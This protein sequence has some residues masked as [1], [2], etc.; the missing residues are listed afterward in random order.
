VSV[1]DRRNAFLRRRA[2]ALLNDANLAAMRQGLLPAGWVYGLNDQRQAEFDEQRRMLI[3]GHKYLFR[4]PVT[5]PDGVAVAIWYEGTSEYRP[6]LLVPYRQLPGSPPDRFTAAV[7]FCIRVINRIMRGIYPAMQLTFVV[8][9]HS[10]SGPPAAVTRSFLSKQDAGAF[11]AQL[12]QRVR[13]GGVE[14]LR[15]DV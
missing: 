3:E 5:G 14:A 2:D 11:T 6:P 1:T 8:Y 7:D 15:Q 12:V 4:E 13:V 10:M 9:A